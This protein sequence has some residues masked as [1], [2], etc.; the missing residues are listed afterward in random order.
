MYAQLMRIFVVSWR[1]TTLRRRGKRG[2]EKDRPIAS[3][4]VPYNF[5]IDYKNCGM[6]SDTMAG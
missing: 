5:R 1:V 4:S 3:E 2:M 6:V